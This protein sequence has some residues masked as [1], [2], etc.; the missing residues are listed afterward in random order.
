MGIFRKKTQGNFTGLE[1]AITGFVMYQHIDLPTLPE[2]INRL[3]HYLESSELTRKIGFV[4]IITD[5]KTLDKDGDVVSVLVGDEHPLHFQRSHSPVPFE[6]LE[7]AQ[8]HVQLLQGSQSSIAVLTHQDSQSSSGTVLRAIISAFAIQSFHDCSPMQG[9][10]W[11]PSSNIVTPQ[12]WT[13]QCA[14]FIKN[15]RIPV[16]LWVQ[17]L[18][19]QHAKGVDAASIGMMGMFSTHDVEIWNSSRD[20]AEVGDLLESAILDTI[21]QGP[22]V[23]RG[24]SWSTTT[25]VRFKAGL[26]R[27]RLEHNEK[28]AR[29]LEFE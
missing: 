17:I 23:R 20:E 1:D 19:H 27:S 4:E 5:P 29:L 12:Q 28:V 18:T 8:N 16:H 7:A 11:N 13:T 10:L 25:G 3:T 15:G 26:K 21:A 14:E 6:R 2:V 9:V 22:I 24:K